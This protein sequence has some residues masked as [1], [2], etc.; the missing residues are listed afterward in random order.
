MSDIRDWSAFIRGRWDWTKHGYEKGFPRGCQFTD[1]DAAVEFDG[2]RLVVE[3]KHHDGIG[4]CDYPDIGQL[5][6]LRDEVRLGKSVIVLYGCGGCNSPQAVRVLGTAK[7]EDRW[8]DWRGRDLAERRRL[9]KHEID[10]ALGLAPEDVV[11]RALEETIWPK[12]R[13]PP[14]DT[15]R[16]T[17]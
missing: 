5:I 8:E 11:D 1:L 9:L 7:A 14:E 15:G 4:P 2:R 13:Q 3:T 17:A 10:R 6:F 16:A 12:A